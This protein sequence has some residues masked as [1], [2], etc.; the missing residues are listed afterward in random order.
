VSE[1]AWAEAHNE[2]TRLVEKIREANVMSEDDVHECVDNAIE[3][4]RVNSTPHVGGG[5]KPKRES[6]T[7]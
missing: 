5:L 4:T 7:G 1:D 6:T 2:L 3:N